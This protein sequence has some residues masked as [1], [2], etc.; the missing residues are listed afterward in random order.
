LVVRLDGEQAIAAFRKAVSLAHAPDWRY[1][2]LFEPLGNLLNRAL[3]RLASRA[4]RTAPGDPES[5]LPDERG[6]QGQ[7]AAHW[8]NGP[9]DGSLSRQ[10][11]RSRP[12]SWITARWLSYFR[13]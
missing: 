4:S 3:W 11:K 13:T 5:A 2:A 6:I 9:S 10:N 1:W 8:M 7:T 12:M